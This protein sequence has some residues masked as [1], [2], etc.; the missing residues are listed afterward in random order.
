M[1]PGPGGVAKGRSWGARAPCIK[2]FCKTRRRGG[3]DNLE[4]TLCLT[5]CDPISLGKTMAKPQGPFSPIKF[6]TYEAAK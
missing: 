4:S 2:T 1:R 3:N 6:P 5:Q